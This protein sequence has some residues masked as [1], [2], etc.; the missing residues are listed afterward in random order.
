MNTLHVQRL[1]HDTRPTIGVL[2]FGATFL[3]FT[4]EDRP[5]EVKVPGD[6]CIPAGTYDLRWRQHGKWA[7]RFREWGFTGSLELINVEGFTDV[8]IHAG[9]TK[10]DT[11]GC[12]LLG[13]VCDMSARTIG[14]SRPAVKGLYEL[15]RFHDR[16]PWQIVYRN[17]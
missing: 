14:R 12:L 5:R 13:Q 3:G 10:R 11:A 6:T 7:A 2:T 15:V 9:N 4:L 1:T 16:D 17:P 8:L